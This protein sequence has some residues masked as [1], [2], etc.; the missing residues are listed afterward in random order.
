MESITHKYHVECAKQEHVGMR[1]L[2]NLFNEAACRAKT[3]IPYQ[4]G[5]KC[6]RIHSPNNR[7][8]ERIPENCKKCLFYIS[9]LPAAIIV[10]F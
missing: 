3:I 1:R 9:K 5:G 2:L 10:F 7:E 4:T 8:E 6:Y